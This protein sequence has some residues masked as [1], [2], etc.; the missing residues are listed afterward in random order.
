MNARQQAWANAAREA[1][2]AGSPAAA[3]FA[4]VAQPSERERGHT[5]AEHARGFTRD[6]QRGLRCGVCRTHLRWVP[7]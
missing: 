3:I 4:L 1:A 7:R 6:G 5:C 2:H